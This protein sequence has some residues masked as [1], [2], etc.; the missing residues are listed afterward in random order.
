M[1]DFILWYLTLQLIGLAALPVTLRLFRHL[2]D[3][4]YAFARPLGLLILG[5]ALWAGVS[6]GFLNNERVTIF[7]LLLIL[8]GVSVWSWLRER[9]LLSE[10]LRQ[11]RRA[12][13]VTEALF[14]GGLALTA[15]LRAYSPEIATAGGEK[16]MEYAF[17]NSIL[18]ADTFPPPDPWLSGFAISYYYLGYLILAMVIKLSGVPAATGFNL[19]H[20]LLYALTLT[21]AFSL[22][23]NLTPRKTTDEGRK[24]EDGGPK[25]EDEG[26]K[27]VDT[28]L[29]MEANSSSVLRPPSSVGSIGFGLLGS[30]LVAVMGNLMGLLEVLHAGGVGS[31]GFWQWLDIKSINGPAVAAG[32][33]PSRFIWWWQA[34][35]VI[36]DN[37]A[38]I[39]DEFPSFS[40]L[41]GDN[42]PHVL[43]LPFVLL[44]IALAV[45]T[46]RQRPGAPLYSPLDREFWLERLAPA[47]VLGALGFLNSWDFPTYTLVFIGAYAIQSWLTQGRRGREWLVDVVQTGLAVG[48]VGLLLYVPFWVGLQSQARGLALQGPI[49][50]RL[51]QYLVMFGPFVVVALAFLGVQAV[52]V[53]RR[54]G[55]AGSRM[56]VIFVGVVTLPSLLVML[57]RGWFTAAFLTLLIG[58]AVAALL[59]MALEAGGSGQAEPAEEAPSKHERRRS[60]TAATATR[61]QNPTLHTLF[62]LL[63]F[64]LAFGLTL[65][66]EFVFIRDN[67]GS[68]M[69]SVFKFYFQAWILL[70]LAS[71]YA[72]WWLLGRERAEGRQ[73]TLQLSFSPVLTLVVGLGLIYPILA[74]I[75]RADNFNHP[76]TLDGTQWVAQQHPDD[77]AAI[78]WLNANVQDQPTILEAPGDQGKS[79][80]YEGR[81][82]AFTGLPTLL[83][84][85]GHQSQWRGN[86]NEPGRREPLIDQIFRTT[87]TRA[88]QQLLDQFGVEYVVYGSVERARYGPTRGPS[89]TKFARF[90][91]EVFRDG[92]TVI[93]R[94]R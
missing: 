62:A 50:T 69:N 8:G 9:D 72:A 75:S 21:G 61:F 29:E 38:E 68:R 87:D 51:P 22:I 42:H 86:Y 70:A 13:Y 35:R 63:L 49:K 20:A 88:A 27:T 78:Q 52:R 83:G 10:T 12:V 48:V 64:A 56:A 66:T 7:V 43:A 80:V 6:F 77:Y 25:T 23:Y 60:A 24:T 74:N 76:P 11:H 14:L 4:G 73:R 71:A 34:S 28:G 92:D 32:W 67:F 36:N 47:L 40:F 58:V 41:L 33:M 31:P 30:V 18:R 59:V 79:Y 57:L 89:A 55:D 3:R 81:I 1:V 16:Y 54:R 15:L 65:G 37:G 26:P 17:I 85:G 46:L 2:P 53:W 91:D 93:Y 44:A 5:V 82:S 94:I 84:W 45:N 19:S 90:M 39:I